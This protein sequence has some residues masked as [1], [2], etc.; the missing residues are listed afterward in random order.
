MRASKRSFVFPPA[1]EP[2]RKKLSRAIPTTSCIMKDH[3][4]VAA[5]GFL[6]CDQSPQHNCRGAGSR[7]GAYSA[8]MA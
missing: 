2:T 6:G 4:V 7:H 5:A 1:V 3:A 8:A